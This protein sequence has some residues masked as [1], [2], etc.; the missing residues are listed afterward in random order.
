M[1]NG[2]LKSIL[3]NY[4]I[5]IRP[6]CCMNPRLSM[7]SCSSAIFPS[8]ILAFALPF[9]SA[10]LSF[11]DLQET[12]AESTQRDRMNF[13]LVGVFVSPEYR[14]KINEPVSIFKKF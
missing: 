13:F 11:S 4:C 12:S 6:S 8:F 3:L 2:L 7:K 14:I 1:Q 10:L 9:T 5:G